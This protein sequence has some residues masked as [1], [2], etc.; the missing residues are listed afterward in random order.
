[1]VA[2]LASRPTVVDFGLVDRG[3]WTSDRFDDSKCALCVL[4]CI[5]N[6]DVNNTLLYLKNTLYGTRYQV[7]Y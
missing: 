3:C 4:N 2:F 6:C 1:M 5:V 7:Q